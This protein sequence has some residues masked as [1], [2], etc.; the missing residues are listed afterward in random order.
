MHNA[1]KYIQIVRS[2]REAKLAYPKYHYAYVRHCHQ[3]SCQE[4]Q[5]NLNF[6]EC[7]AFFVGTET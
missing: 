4:L 1:F 5:M 2:L 6:P 3:V 7:G